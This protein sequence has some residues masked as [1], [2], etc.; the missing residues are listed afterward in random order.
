MTFCNVSFTFSLAGIRLFKYEMATDLAEANALSFNRQHIDIYSNSWGPDDRGFEVKG[1]GRATQTA[2]R[3]G[4][5][6]VGEEAAHQSLVSCGSLGVLSIF[7]RY[8]LNIFL[9]E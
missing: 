1:P 6:K 5:T 9:S 7:R 3:E 8:N 4:A 2:L